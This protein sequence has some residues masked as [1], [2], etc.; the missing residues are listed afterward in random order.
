MFLIPNRNIKVVAFV[1]VIA[2]RVVCA[3]QGATFGSLFSIHE[4]WLA[5]VPYQERKKCLE[6]TGKFH[7]SQIPYVVI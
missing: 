2:A 4:V 6:L 5:M 7:S 1:S 3:W